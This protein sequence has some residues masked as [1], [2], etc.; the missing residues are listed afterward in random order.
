ML[1][2]SSRI[3]AQ[4]LVVRSLPCPTVPRGCVRFSSATT[5]RAALW[6]G[7][8]R[9]ENEEENFGLRKRDAPESFAAAAARDAARS[10]SS[11]ASVTD[12]TITRAPAGDAEVGAAR[13]T[14]RRASY[15]SGAPLDASVRPGLS[16]L[17]T[18]WGLAD[19]SQGLGFGA[20]TAGE[21][22]LDQ[23]LEA[24]CQNMLLPQV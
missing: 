24:F 7:A 6:W 1:S 8:Q 10:S 14:F 13:P 16:A 19:D 15:T 23:F 3:H 18:R 11:L 21:A 9:E 17:P 20:S 4:R 22:V 2:G 5:Q 12:A